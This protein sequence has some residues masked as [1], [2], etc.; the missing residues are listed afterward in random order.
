MHPTFRSFPA[1]IQASFSDPIILGGESRLDSENRCTECIK[2]KKKKIENLP[3]N[4]EDENNS[5]LNAQIQKAHGLSQ[6]DKEKK[7]E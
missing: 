1:S 3:K 4:R 6:R 7:T 2:K 5:Y